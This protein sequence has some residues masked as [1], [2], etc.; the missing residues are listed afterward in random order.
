MFGNSD[1]LDYTLLEN[2]RWP[3]RGELVRQQSKPWRNHSHVSQTHPARSLLR[4]LC[5]QSTKSRG[6]PSYCRE[7]LSSA[8]PD[9]STTQPPYELFWFSLDIIAISMVDGHRE[10]VCAA[11]QA[12]LDYSKT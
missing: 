9:L 2:F 12:S 11:G 3:N 10:G 7:S 8:R 6:D 1:Y 4:N 5:Q